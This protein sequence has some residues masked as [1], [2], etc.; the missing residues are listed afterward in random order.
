MQIE[1]E[2][3]RLTAINLNGRG[4]NSA[5]NTEPGQESASKCRMYVG[6]RKPCRCPLFTQVLQRSGTAFRKYPN[7]SDRI[8]IFEEIP[9]VA[10]TLAHEKSLS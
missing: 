8:R 4:V 9:Y 1:K 6:Q 5:W 7:S 3:V 10:R 2:K